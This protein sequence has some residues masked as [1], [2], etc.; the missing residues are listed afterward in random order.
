MTRSFKAY[1]IIMSITWSMALVGVLMYSYGPSDF[2]QFW[3]MAAFTVII[4][5]WVDYR[6]NKLEEKLKV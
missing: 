2:A 4:I 3:S 1:T 6:F 5:Y